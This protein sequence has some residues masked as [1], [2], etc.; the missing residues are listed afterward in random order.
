MNHFPHT[1]MRRLRQTKHLRDMFNMPF[2]AP[3][4]FIWPTFVVSGS[5]IKEEISAMPG[6]YIFSPDMLVAEMNALISSGISSVLLFGIPNEGK[7]NKTGSSALLK[8]DSVYKA[9]SLLRT[10]YPELTIFTDVCMCAYTNHGHCGILDESGHLDND[11][12]IKQLAEIAIHHAKAGAT[13]V[14][15]S[16]MADGQVLGIR[17]KLDEHGFINTL[18]MSYS[19]KFASSF[20]GPFR[21]VEQSSPG[22]GNRVAYQQSMADS[23]QALRESL[24][25]EVEGADILMV[26]PALSYLDI[27]VKIRQKTN[28]PLATYN[29]SG[30]YSM[31][32]ATAEKGWGNLYEMASETLLAMNRAGADILISYWANQYGKLIKDNH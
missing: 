7:K 22:G 11:A 23:K 19:T 24:L 10:S 20:Y 32:H 3:E 17:K 2:P 21:E 25:D 12:S 5:G 13:G 31:L 1:R 8:D 30:E 28:L 4:K 29:V 6:Q 27:I 18:I 16:A 15:P 14:A 9:I 26:K